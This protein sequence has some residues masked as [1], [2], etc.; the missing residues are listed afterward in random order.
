MMRASFFPLATAIF[1]A[2]EPIT[3]T[4]TSNTSEPRAAAVKATFHHAWDGYYEFAFPHDQLQPLDN[5]YNDNYDGWGASAI[6]ALSTAIIMGHA[7]I[8]NQILDYIPIVDFTQTPTDGTIS[9][10]ETTIRYL[11]GLLAG[12]DLLNGPASHLINDQNKTDAILG[13]ATELADSLAFS[14]N[15]GSGIPHNNIFLNNQ[16]WDDSSTNGLATI[17]TLVLEWTRLS[18]LTGNQTYANLSQKAQSYLMSPQPSWAEPFPG[19]VGSNIDIE[20]GEFQDDQV[21]WNGGDDSFYEYLIKFYIY[22]PSRFSDYRDRWEAAANSTIE[23]L[24]SHPPLRP[25]LTFVRNYNNGSWDNSSQHLTGFIGGNFILGG[26][27]LKRTDLI[28]YGLNLTA[29]WHHTYASS[30]SHV[31]PDS[32][33]WNETQVPDD[34]QEFYNQTGIYS[35]NGNYILRPEV[36]ESYYYAW[37]ITGDEKYRD[38]VWDAY[39]AIN[40]TTSAGSGNAELANVYDAD[41]GGY[42][43]NQDS[44][45]FA[46]VLKYCY[47]TFA[48]DADWQ[49]K[50]NGLNKFVFNTEAHPFLIQE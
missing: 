41:G 40:E 5:T 35:T 13:K 39:V 49:V 15:S 32:F 50:A 12:Y 19:L 1:A 6:D 9:L 34:Q 27:V 26:T 46:E 20:S 30:T 42:Q 17:G 7:D 2:I 11:G 25:D 44:F 10:F 16:S 36:I 45:F 33:G 38:W 23:N 29:A 18:D 8:V 24:T 47:L 37:R 22:S 14:F 21:T 3:A 48:D 31:G 43:N 4:A 28:E